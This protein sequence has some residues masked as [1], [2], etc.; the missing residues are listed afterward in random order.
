MTFMGVA[1]VSELVQ[2]RDELDDLRTRVIYLEHQRD[3]DLGTSTKA[4]AAARA[5]DRQLVKARSEWQ[6]VVKG[7]EAGMGQII[8][9]L[10]SPAA[11]LPALRPE[12]TQ[13]ASESPLT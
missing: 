1:A 11:N 13:S 10:T 7:L 12:N 9:L 6:E 8:S 5:A 4:S 3:V 2:L